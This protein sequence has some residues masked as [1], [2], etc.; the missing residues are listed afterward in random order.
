LKIGDDGAQQQ[1]TEI[2][3]LKLFVNRKVSSLLQGDFGGQ[4][5]DTGKPVGSQNLRIINHCI[6]GV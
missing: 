4:D 2:L 6:G 3:K 1:E 5:S